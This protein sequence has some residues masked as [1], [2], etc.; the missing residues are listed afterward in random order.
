MQETYNSQKEAI[1]KLS[2]IKVSDLKRLRA[3]GIENEGIYLYKD[4]IFKVSSSRK[5]FT[6]AN[7]IK[8]KDFKNVV[9]VYNTYECYSYIGYSSNIIY[10]SYIIEEEKLFRNRK[11]YVFDDLDVSFISSD[12]NRRLPFIVS[13]INGIA[14]LAS[15]GIIHNDLH[16]MNIMLDKH[17]Q[18]KI[19]DFGFAKIKKQ[20]Q[21]VNV[22]A[23]TLYSQ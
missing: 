1:A 18:V 19:I 22:R 4:R 5:E 6:A 12:I 3:A 21:K 20:F 10:K 15:I 9:K 7:R 8:N 17:N 23:K 13:V 2:N 16:S 14:E 11:S